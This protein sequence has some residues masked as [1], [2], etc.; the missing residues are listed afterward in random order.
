MADSHSSTA[1]D[2]LADIPDPR[3]DRGK[4]NPWWLIL[5]LLVLERLQGTE[6][7]YGIGM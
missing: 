3:K 1:I 7:P 2:I 6:T 4:R 5:P